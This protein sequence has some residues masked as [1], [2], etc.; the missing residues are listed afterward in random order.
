[1]DWGLE[2]AG[3]RAAKAGRRA[4]R[5]GLRAVKAGQRAAK[6]GLRGDL[7]LVFTNEVGEPLYARSVLRADFKSIADKANLPKTL[8]LYDLR[9]TTATL[10]LA[11]G[12]N[13]KVVSERLGHASAAM[14]LDVYAHTLPGL[15]EEATARL[16]AV[17]FPRES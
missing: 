8:R 15:Q 10:L 13:V 9:H 5:G 11:S 2:Q 16:E 6:A 3:L 4:V 14:T 12:V 17:I 1:M 7:D